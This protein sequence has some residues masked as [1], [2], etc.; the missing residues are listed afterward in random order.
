[1]PLGGNTEELESPPGALCYAGA[2]PKILIVEDDELLLDAVSGQ[3]D[4]L[5]YSVCAA[6]SVAA[7][8]AV[9]ADQPVDGIVLDL[10]L[11]DG[12]GLALLPWAR[13]RLPGLPVLV[14][15]AREGVD[16]RVR[17]LNAG[18]DDYM[19]KPFSMA[20]LQARLQAMIRRARLPAFGPGAASPDGPL[21]VG[22]LRIDLAAQAAWLDGAPLDLTQRE[23]DLLALLAQRCGEVVTRE[24]VLAAWH[25]LPPEPGQS[26]GAATS[27]A[28]EV[29]VHRLRRKLDV[30]QLNI[31]NIRGLGY[32]LEQRSA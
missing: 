6:G 10:G 24:D 21:A 2:M 26:P 9:L 23:W 18:A 4:Q 7:A 1:M 3:L 8:R 25:A 19:T 20:E 22:P 32:M 30:P 11:P 14:L 28:L 12:D 15:T 5:G 29:Y 27:N 17:G 13:Q 31:R 16:D